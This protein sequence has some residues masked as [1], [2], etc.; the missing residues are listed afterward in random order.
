MNKAKQIAC[1]TGAFGMVG[2]KIVQR[3]VLDGYKVRALSRSKYF[4]VPDVELFCGG[5]EDEEV[6]KSFLSNT[7]LLFHCAAELYD[8]SK[9]WNVNVLGTEQLLRIV[10]E[11][12]IQY[13]CYLSS[14]GVVG[15]TNVKLVNEK[16]ICKP[17]NAYE[18]SKW[19][20][21]Q[22]V[23]E[24]IDGC[25]IV[26]L[27]PTNVIDNK[28]PGALGLPMR[29][30]WLDRF[31]VFLKGG[32]CAHIVHAEDVAEAAMY[33]ISRPFNT[34]RCFFVSCDNEPL[35][36]FAGLRALYRAIENN[37]PVG[38][39]RPALHLPL[40]VPHI[41]RQLRRGKGNRGDVRY[42]SEKIMSEGFKFSIGTKGAVTDLLS[43]RGSK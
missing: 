40:I 21:E 3:L 10:K 33:F 5:L 22:L 14:A 30:S 26:I 1:V 38:S 13:L 31:K 15:R 19:A 2:S 27:R 28:R 6:L 7:D 42:S 4:D 35:N 36:T 17:Q 34:P 39:V 29:N 25:T 20:A 32:E 43:T 8:E 11:S 24:G 12:H 23:A 9:M 41:L 18:Q 16:T 37:R